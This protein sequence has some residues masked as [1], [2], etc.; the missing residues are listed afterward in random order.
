MTSNSEDRLV[1]WSLQE[2]GSESFLKNLIQTPI[3]LHGFPPAPPKPDSPPEV[4]SL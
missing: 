4:L 2:N 3:M 1:N